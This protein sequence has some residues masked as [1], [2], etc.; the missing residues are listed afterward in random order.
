MLIV[1]YQLVLLTVWRKDEEAEYQAGCD[2]IVS[3]GKAHPH[4]DTCW[5]SIGEEPGDGNL[6]ATIRRHRRAVF[7]SDGT[8]SVEADRR[9]GGNVYRKSF[10]PGAEAPWAVLSSVRQML[11]APIAP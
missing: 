5:F 3:E 4:D 2:A 8:F 9:L 6:H 7:L 1:T 10:N 11:L